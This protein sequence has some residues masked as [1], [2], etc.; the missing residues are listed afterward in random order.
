[1]HSA[2]HVK[3][4]KFPIIVALTSIPAISAATVIDFEGF[5]LGQ[6]IDTEY[7][8]LGATISSVNFVDGIEGNADDFANGQ[9]IFDTDNPTGGD[10]D[11][12][13]PFTNGSGLGDLF[14]GDVLILHERVGDCD[15]V[16][17]FCNPPAGPDDEG[18]R[19][20][21]YIEIIFD[22]EVTVVS[23]DFFDIETLED[24]TTPDN[25][26]ELYN[27]AN[28]QIFDDSFYTPDT[29]GNNTWDQLMIGQSGIS[30]MVI[31]MGGSGA[32]DNIVFVP[33]PGTL[34]LLGAG[35]L[36]LFMRRKRVA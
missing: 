19:P 11:L 22:S 18:S 29:G 3:Y 8:F 26:V 16:A 2:V 9:V 13:A 5:G 10:G 33:E 4:W 15:F 30:R 27:A 20:A 1:M 35:L 14:P 7:Q 28:V 25:E 31:R 32:I 36:G 34:G 23:I 6:I 17:G 21:G 12:A 24:G